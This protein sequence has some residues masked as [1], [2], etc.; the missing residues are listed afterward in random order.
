[1]DSKAETKVDTSLSGLGLNRKLE[2][3]RRLIGK[4]ERVFGLVKGKRYKEYD[5]N[6]RP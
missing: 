1:M 6:C 4:I 5:Y 3:Y 2:A